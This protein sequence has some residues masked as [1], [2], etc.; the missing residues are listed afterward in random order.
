MDWQSM[1]FL[2][3]MKN[4]ITANMFQNVEFIFSRSKENCLSKRLSKQVCTVKNAETPEGFSNDYF[5]VGLGSSTSFNKF[6]YMDVTQ[7]N[8][9]GIFFCWSSR[10]YNFICVMCFMFYCISGNNDF[11][12][13]DDDSNYDWILD[14]TPRGLKKKKN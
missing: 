11:A 7:G 13:K 5:F 4:Y 3:F 9:F 8:K 6:L 12:N 10:L 2:F 1:I 14:E